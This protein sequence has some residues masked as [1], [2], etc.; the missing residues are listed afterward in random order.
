MISGALIP[1]M[2]LI[3][4]IFGILSQ[5]TSNQIELASIVS[6]PFPVETSTVACL[7]QISLV[8]PSFAVESPVVI[9]ALDAE[10]CSPF[11]GETLLLPLL[12]MIVLSL[13]PSVNAFYFL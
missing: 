4:C 13:S 5:P 12:S 1:W 8:P 6:P 7:L 3:L 11:C 2:K 9:Y 10:A